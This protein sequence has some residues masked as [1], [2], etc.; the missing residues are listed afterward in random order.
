M[1]FSAEIIRPDA[2]HG[3]KKLKSYFPAGGLIKINFGIGETA[4]KKRFK[5]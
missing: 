4:S 2:G 1:S 3:A 5:I